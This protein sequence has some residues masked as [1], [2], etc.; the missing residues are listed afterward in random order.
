MTVLIVVNQ[1]PIIDKDTVIRV[2]IL[3][4]D[5][6]GVEENLLECENCRH[7]IEEMVAIID[8]SYDGFFYHRR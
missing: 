5:V 2:M 6:S 3:I 7:M 4:Q 8:S 1:I